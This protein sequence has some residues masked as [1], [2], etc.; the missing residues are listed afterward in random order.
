M[1]R[2]RE[3]GQSFELIITRY[4]LERLLYRMSVS[5]HAKRFVLKSVMLLASRFT[6]PHRATRDLDLLGFGDPNSGALPDVFREIATVDV[7]DGVEFDLD[8]TCLISSNHCNL[9][10]DVL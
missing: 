5:A 7:A 2:Y 10:H 4:A 6:E 1:L 9:Q 3:T 8:V